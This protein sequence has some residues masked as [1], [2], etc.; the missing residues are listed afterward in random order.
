M[1]SVLINMII[2][3]RIFSKI[4]LMNLKQAFN[5]NHKNNEKCVSFGERHIQAEDAV[6]MAKVNRD[7]IPILHSLMKGGSKE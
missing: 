7:Q 2:I 1:L 4:F 5:L 3:D 6:P